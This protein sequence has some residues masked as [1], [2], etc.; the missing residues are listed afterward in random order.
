LLFSGSHGKSFRL[1]DPRQ[2]G[3]Q[4]A[5]VCQDWT[6]YGSISKDQYYDAS[7]LS[8][9]AKVHGVIHLLFACYGA[10]WPQFDNFKRLESS[11]AQIAPKP[12][13]G[14][15]PQA[16]LA[17]PE[18]GA[19]A[20]LGH[21]ERAWA[22]SFHSDRGGP[23]IQGFRDVIGRIMRGDRL[24]QATDQFNFRWAALS[25][26]LS[27]VLSQMQ[28]GLQVPPQ[29]LANQWVARDDARNYILFGDPAVRLRVED[30]PPIA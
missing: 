17:H 5:I 19:L 20:V 22:F 24:G 6:G 12:M 11:P 8:A 25:T 1:D 16:L 30:M 7:D 2:E 18:G 4:G 28:F 3:S 27:E 10:G 21:V 23:Q 26:E 13:M 15:L 14:R 29:Q 9:N